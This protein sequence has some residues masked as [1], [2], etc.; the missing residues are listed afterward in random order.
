MAFYLFILAA[1]TEAAFDTSAQAAIQFT[2]FSQL[3]FAT[4]FALEFSLEAYDAIWHS[5]AQKSSA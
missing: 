1:K 3:T 2:P 4:I 5:M